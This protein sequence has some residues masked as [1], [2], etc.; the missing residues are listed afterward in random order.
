M[1]NVVNELITWSKELNVLY[2]E[3]DPTLREEISLFLSDI[4]PHIDLASNGEE[5]LLKLAQNHYHLVITDI[6]MPIM[7][8]IEM[9]EKIKEFYPQQPILVTSAH[10]ESE[11]L[12]KLI[13]LGVNNFITKPL[14][15]DQILQVLFQIVE[16]I[17]QEQLLNQYKKDLE[18]ANEKLKKFAHMQSK[19]LDLKTSFLRAY[20]EALDKATIVSITNKDGIITDVN[21]NYCKATG[22]SRDEIVGQNYKIITHPSTNPALY[23]EIWEAL[24]AKKTWQGLI[25]SQSRTL[26]PLYHY[27]TI[28]PI[29]DSQGNIMEYISIIQDITELYKKQEEKTKENITL[30]M[31]VK[32]D[33]LLKNIPFGAALLSETLTFLNYNKRFEELVNNHID[34]NLLLKLTQQTLKLKELVEFEEMDLFTSIEEIKNNWPYDGD[35]TFKGIVKSVGHMLEVLVK[36]SQYEPNRYMICIVKQEDF[37]LCCQVQER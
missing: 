10:N 19:S 1:E 35:I 15:S 12:V 36:I 23:D 27:K 25:I 31:N 4:F 33:E 14:Q 8:G 20:K 13:N 9:I 18:I 22:Y 2:V 37:E 21:E 29:F 32:E 16:K 26:E 7:D 11:Y 28:V 5:G 30:A 34:E 24:L 6:R 3:D 17:H